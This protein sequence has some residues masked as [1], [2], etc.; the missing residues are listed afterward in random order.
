MPLLPPARL[1][2]TPDGR[3][4]FAGRAVRT[5]GFGYLSVVLPLYLALH[6]FS[7]REIGAVLTA[8]VA[9]AG[10]LV[11]RWTTLGVLARTLSHQQAMA[12]QA[13]HDRL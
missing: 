12:A 6:G 9:I 8:V 7:P 10:L 1:G 13:Q 4:L 5:F 11:N 2:L 3:L